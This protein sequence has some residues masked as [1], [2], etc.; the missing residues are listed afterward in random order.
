[1]V[2]QVLRQNLDNLHLLL[3]RE[4]CNGRLN[5]ASNGGVVNGDEAG[6]VEE[7]NGSHDKLAVHAV[8][9]AAVSRNGV[10]KVLDLESALKTGGE[11]ATKGC[12]ERGKR[13]ENEDVELHGHDVERLWDG[14]AG[15]DEWE[16]VVACNEN[17]IGP[18][19]ET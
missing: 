12:D 7:C 10:A 4:S 8:G 3:S 13:C 15:W 17:R 1:L 14:D 5:H 6:V 16:R 19:F 18:A 11:E 9:H 2:D